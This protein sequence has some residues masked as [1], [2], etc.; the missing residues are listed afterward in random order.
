MFSGC[1][2]PLFLY[3]LYM[4]PEEIEFQKKQIEYYASCVNAWFNTKLERD[5][6]LLTLSAGGIG[7]LITLL[8]TVGLSSVGNPP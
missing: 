7:L 5:R 3:N 6:S 2:A 1:D 8:T 4:T